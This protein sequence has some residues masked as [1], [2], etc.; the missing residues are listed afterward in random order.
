[1]LDELLLLLLLL[2]EFD[3][4]LLLLLLLVVFGPLL[5]FAVLLFVLLP[6]LPATDELEPDF[7]SSFT[8]STASFNAL[9]VEVK[10]S[11]PLLS[12]LFAVF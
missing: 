9:A 5:V 1:M 11:E 8:S 4:L 6:V 2:L 7:F 3:D 10:A 12:D